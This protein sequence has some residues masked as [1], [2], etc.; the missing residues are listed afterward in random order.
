MI[1]VLRVLSYCVAEIKIVTLR[2]LRSLKGNRD[3]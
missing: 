1:V 3:I 2:V